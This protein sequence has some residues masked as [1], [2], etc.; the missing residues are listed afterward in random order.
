MSMYIDEEGCI[1]YG[2]IF[3]TKRFKGAVCVPLVIV[4]CE[5]HSKRKVPFY[6]RM[7]FFNVA[8]GRIMSLPLGLWVAQR[9]IRNGVSYEM[10]E[11]IYFKPEEVVDYCD[12]RGYKS[13]LNLIGGGK[14][15]RRYG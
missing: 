3:C 11:K 14:D 9:K 5:Y 8:K 13:L 10:I 15:E 1:R 6:K 12:E 2:S 4:S 7:V